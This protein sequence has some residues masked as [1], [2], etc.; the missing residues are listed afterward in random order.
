MKCSYAIVPRWRPTSI[1]V[2]FRV[3][4][5][6]PISLQSFNSTSAFLSVVLERIP[7]KIIKCKID[8]GGGGGEE[9]KTL[10]CSKDRV[11]RNMMGR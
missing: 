9:E 3:F 8:E 1:Y 4:T 6:K 2:I 10:E 11:K 5:V 7:N